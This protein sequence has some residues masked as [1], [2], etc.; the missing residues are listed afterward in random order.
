MTDDGVDEEP[1]IYDV[2]N[3]SVLSLYGANIGHGITGSLELDSVSG[4]IR[5]PQNR[6][7]CS[8]KERCGAALYLAEKKIDLQKVV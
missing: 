6:F 5:G 8:S 2:F 3:A 4:A 7:T 1:D